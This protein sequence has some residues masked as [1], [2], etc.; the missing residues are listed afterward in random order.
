MDGEDGDSIPRG[1]LEKKTSIAAVEAEYGTFQGL[2]DQWRAFKAAMQPGDE[3][4]WFSSPADSW[5]A[6]AGRA[7]LALVRS[8]APIRCMVTLMN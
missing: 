1:W 4:W 5:A 6:L 7:G 8:G 2:A 3:I